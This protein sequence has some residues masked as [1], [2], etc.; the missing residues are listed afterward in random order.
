MPYQTPD[1]PAS[2]VQKCTLDQA[3]FSAFSPKKSA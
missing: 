1:S 2:F 3:A